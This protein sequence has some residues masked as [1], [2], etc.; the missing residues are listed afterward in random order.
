M[1]LTR[2][3]NRL[4]CRA[5]IG[6]MLFAQLATAA[7]ACPGLSQLVAR[8]QGLQAAFGGHMV[9]CDQMG[10]SSHNPSPNLCA[11]HC[12]YG[13]QSS[14]VHTPAT[15][16]VALVSLYPIV[17]TALDA[18]LPMSAT[19]ASVDAHAAALTPHAILHCVFRL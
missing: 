4:M 9:T 15:P 14:Q 1:R 5:L 13:E 6:L 3:F 10:R 11:E 8:A 12:R 7:H 16:A 17:P 19:S 2:S 18:A